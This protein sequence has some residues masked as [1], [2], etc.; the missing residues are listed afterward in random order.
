MFASYK[1]GWLK[2]IIGWVVVFLIRLVPFRPPNIEPVLTMMMPFAKRYGAS[3]AFLFGFLSIAFFDLAS[4][5][6]G[7]WTLITGAAYGAV[8]IGAYF[9]FRNRA[10]SAKNFLVYAVIGTLLYDAV[11]GL[12]IGPLFFGQSFMEA[13][14]GQISFTL[15]HLLGNIA[16]S[17]TLSPAIYR[18]VVANEKLEVGALSQKLVAKAAGR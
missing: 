12:T 8:G 13:L 3:G 18:W 16:F 1:T 4:G 11:T 2:Y 5:L 17:V 9:F 10:A 6:V 14:T 15:L 7:Q